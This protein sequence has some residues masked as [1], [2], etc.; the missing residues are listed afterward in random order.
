MLGSL[1]QSGIFNILLPIILVLLL[2]VG[3]QQGGDV[4]LHLVVVDWGE[5]PQQERPEGGHLGLNLHLRVA[6]MEI[7][8]KSACVY[9]FYIIVDCLNV[10]SIIESIRGPLNTNKNK[11]W[12]SNNYPQ[13]KWPTSIVRLASKCDWLTLVSPTFPPTPDTWQQSSF[14]SRDPHWSS[15]Q[16]VWAEL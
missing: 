1:R 15:V 16:P 12:A 14:S 11:Y 8:E 10:W 13:L 6:T 7:I 5:L 3:S 9:S 2:R 4:V